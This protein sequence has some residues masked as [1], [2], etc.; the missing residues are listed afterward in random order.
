[1]NLEL[2]VIVEKIGLKTAMESLRDY[3]FQRSDEAVTG[4]ETGTG[5]EDMA[6]KI[7]NIIP[8][9][10]DEQLDGEDDD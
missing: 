3:C 5:W 8:E 4:G 1:V 7:D 2:A 9:R 6:Y 10:T